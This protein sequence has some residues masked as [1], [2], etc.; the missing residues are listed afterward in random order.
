MLFPS[1]VQSLLSVVSL[2]LQLAT[3]AAGFPPS[4]Q[5][6]LAFL[7]TSPA[8]KISAPS[9]ARTLHQQGP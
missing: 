7:T 8:A 6:L 2:L 1:K 3:G 4:Y 9:C 5:V